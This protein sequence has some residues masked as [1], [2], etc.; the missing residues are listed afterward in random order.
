M[1][2]AM[3][4]SVLGS[5]SRSSPPSSSATG[6]V[7]AR[8]ADATRP[9]VPLTRMFQA[10]QSPPTA[11]DMPR[12]ST[13]S[14]WPTIGRK[15]AKA[16]NG[17]SLRTRGGRGG[18][19]GR[20]AGAGGGQCGRGDPGDGGEG[21]QQQPVEPEGPERLPGGGHHGQDEQQGGRDLALGRGAVQA[22]RAGRG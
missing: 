17:S 15:N 2:P 9:R 13:R 11:S 7:P 5:R 8:I 4:V 14:P 22:A 16:R 3:T 19:G 6:V 20:G 10:P 21:G 18:G 1:N 12:T